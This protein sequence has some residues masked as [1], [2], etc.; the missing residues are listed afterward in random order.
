MSEIR[1]GVTL[2]VMGEGWSMGPFSPTICPFCTTGSYTTSRIWRSLA[3]RRSPPEN[4]TRCTC[5]NGYAATPLRLVSKYRNSTCCT[6]KICAPTLPDGRPLELGEV[7]RNPDLAK[8]LPFAN[9]DDGRPFITAMFTYAGGVGAR[10]TK[11]GLSACSYPTGVSDALSVRAMADSTYSV[12]A[13]SCQSARTA[14]FTPA[15]P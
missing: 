6:S 7:F 8:S 4:S 3:M 5:E 15:S 2:E 1:Q 13:H 10:A 9:L 14:T 12:R 11:P